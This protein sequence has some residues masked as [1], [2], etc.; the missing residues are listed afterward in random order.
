MIEKSLVKKEAQRIGF[1]LIGF[2]GTEPFYKIRKILKKRKKNNEL[3]PFITKDLNLLTNP[4][5]H[6]KSAKSIISLAISYDKTKKNVNNLEYNISSYTIGRD[7]HL[8]LEK[9]LNKLSNFL[10]RKTEDVKTKAYV[11]TGPI[12]DRAAAERAGLGW[13]GKNNNLI[14]KDFGSYIF[15]GEIITNLNFKPD[16]K[17]KNKCGSCQKC[18]NICP[19]NALVDE[20]HIKPDRCISYLTQKKGIIPVTERKK[21]GDNLWG[22]DR[23]QEVCPYNE[24]IISTSDKKNELNFKK[25]LSTILNFSKENFPEEWKNSALSWRGIRILIR[26]A[27]IVIANSKLESYKDEVKRLFDHPSSVIRS[28]AYWTYSQIS[29]D[30]KKILKLNLKKEKTSEGQKELENILY[31]R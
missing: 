28:Y 1:D 9:K 30:Y 15:L 20:H 4:K 17:P 25:D 24:N 27:L 29:D 12:L 11:D 6:M 31:K 14:N 23:C 19:G 7:Y 21:I 5:N 8:I 2:T 18:L 3:S 16:T 26:N 10:Q 13:I 22:C